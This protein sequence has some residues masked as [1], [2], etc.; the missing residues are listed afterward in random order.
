MDLRQP[1]EAAAKEALASGSCTLMAGLVAET[2]GFVHPGK[3]QPRAVD[4][5]CCGEVWAVAP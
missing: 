1:L 2:S 4:Q 3:V 5:E